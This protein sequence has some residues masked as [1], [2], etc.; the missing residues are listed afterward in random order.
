MNNFSVRN[1]FS[2]HKS[3][4]IAKKNSYIPAFLK[5]NEKIWCVTIT[6]LPLPNITDGVNCMIQNAC[7]KH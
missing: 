7:Q 6:R 2:F 1:I 3:K 4:V 5:L